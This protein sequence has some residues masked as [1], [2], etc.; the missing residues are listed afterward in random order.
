MVKENV[1]RIRPLAIGQVRLFL[2]LLGGYQISEPAYFHVN[3]STS[4][5]TNTQNNYSKHTENEI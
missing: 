4:I 3:F 2:H 5:G 1:S